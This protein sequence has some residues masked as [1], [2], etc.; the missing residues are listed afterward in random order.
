MSASPVDPEYAPAGA[1]SGREYF[2]VRYPLRERPLFHAPGLVAT[3]ADVSETGMT[4]VA[5]AGARAKVEPGERVAGLIHFR[6]AEPAM[7]DGV[8]LR[9]VPTGLVLWFDRVGV[10]WGSVQAEERAINARH[11]F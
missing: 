3:I 7:V 4:L 5:P 11:P 8:V 1:E 9:I 2:R 10:S 6:H